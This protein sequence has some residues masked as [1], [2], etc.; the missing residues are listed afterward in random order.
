MGGLGV[1]HG[2]EEAR[3]VGIAL[4]VGDLGERQ[5]LLRSLA[6]AASAAAMF[7]AVIS[8]L[9]SAAGGVFLKGSAMVLCSSFV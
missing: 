1:G 6:L 8:P 7:W 9:A 4:D 3:D 2:A 5:V